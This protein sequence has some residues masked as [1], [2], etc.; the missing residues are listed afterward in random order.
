LIRTVRQ[1]V[2]D[3]SLFWNAD[4]LQRKLNSYQE[5]FNGNRSHQGVNGLTPLQKSDP[6]ISEV[7]PIKKYQWKRKCRGLF[8]LPIAA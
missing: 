5:Y 3:Q 7:I 2:L 6:D 4:D 8:Q 1:E